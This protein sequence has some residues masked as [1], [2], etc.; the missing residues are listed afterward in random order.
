MLPVHPAALAT[1]IPGH[2]LS[3]RGSGAARAPGA[4]ARAASA[5]RT[6]PHHPAP[7]QKGVGP[8]RVGVQQ[9]SERKNKD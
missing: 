3:G 4:A 2:R 9:I 7:R 5:P 6:A 1:R 8:Q